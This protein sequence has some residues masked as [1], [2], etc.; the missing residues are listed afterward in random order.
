MTF[1]YP[2]LFVI[3]II[4][5]LVILLKGSAVLFTHLHFFKKKR[6]FS[7]DMLLDLLTLLF[8]TLA[9]M[10]P[11]SENTKQI[12]IKSVIVRDMPAKSSNTVLVM[13]VSLSMKDGG[14][15]EAEKNDA[16]E[17]ISKTKGYFAVVAF[18]KEYKLLKDFT[19]IKP[20]LYNTINSLKANMITNIGGSRL[21][22]TIAYAINLVKNRPNPKIVIF[23]DGSDNDESSLTIEELLKEAYRHHIKI[24]YRAYGD[25]KAN[26][27]YTQAFNYVDSL[28]QLKDTLDKPKEEELVST[29]KISYEERETIPLFVLLSILLLGVRIYFTRVAL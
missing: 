11:Y 7:K 5:T 10:S 20:A 26:T 14:Y 29:K 2:Y 8:I 6:A 13:D 17:Y 27:P 16:K 21:K 18:E 4:G 12:Q 9:A 1:L 25:D 23:S 19:K 28:Y 22:D 3:F 24:L 15:L